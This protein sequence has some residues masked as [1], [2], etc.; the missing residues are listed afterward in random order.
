MFTTL[1][2]NNGK[3]RDM[4]TRNDWSILY[5]SDIIFSFKPD[6]NDPSVIKF[7]SCMAYLK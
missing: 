4:H 6:D 1:K 7:Q 3:A 2:Q 5:A